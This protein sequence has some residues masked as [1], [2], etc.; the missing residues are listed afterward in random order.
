MTATADPPLRTPA[1]TPA[2]WLRAEVW[3]VFAVS[4]G[5][6]GL[7][8]L[9]HLL[10]DLTNGTA[11]TAQTATLNGSQAPGRPW[12]DLTLQLVSLASGVVPVFL[13]WHFLIRSG[14]GMSAI[15]VDFTRPRWDLIRGAVIAAVIG[16]SGLALYLGAHASGINLTVVAEALPVVWWRIPV[17]V[18]SAMQNGILEEVVVLGYLL[19]RLKQLGW[20]DN[21]ALA[22][23]AVLRGSYHLY[24]GFGGFLGNAIM[25]VI[26]GWL[27]QRWGRAMPMLIA[28]V[29]IDA[30]AFIGYA[31]LAGH[32]SWLPVPSV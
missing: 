8:A 14:E 32:V 26:F 25:G 19:H 30:V 16:G 2:K 28:H 23:S 17:L 29:L 5:A 15:G 24:Q 31:E 6:S 10:A 13:V 7:R 9:I 22:L 11:L 3:L 21:R 20:R 12:L 1:G 4:L 27:F 18:L